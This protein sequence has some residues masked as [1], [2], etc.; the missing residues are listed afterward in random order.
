ML[1]V[2]HTLGGSQSKAAGA[3]VKKR[4]TDG[5]F[6]HELLSRAIVGHQVQSPDCI[7][8]WQCLYP[9]ACSI[10]DQLNIHLL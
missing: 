9:D 4:V 3:L 6:S 8:E 1:L 10:A 2:L 5:S 7:Q